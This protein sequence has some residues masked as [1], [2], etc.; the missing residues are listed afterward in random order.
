MLK[1][2]FSL[3]RNE[4]MGFFVCVVIIIILIVYRYQV[5]KHFTPVTVD[6]SVLE[7]SAAFHY[8]K[9]LPAKE[10][11]Y[12]YAQDKP[13][14]YVPKEVLPVELNSATKA[15]LIALRGVGEFYATKIIEMRKKMGG[16]TH[17]DQ[18]KEVYGMTDENFERIKPQLTLDA[19]LAKSKTKPTPV[20][21]K[22]S[23]PAKH[24][25][26]ELNTASKSELIALNGI[27]EFY[28]TKIIEKREQLGGFSH[29]DQLKM[30]YGMTAENFD[31]MRSQLR[32]DTTLVKEKIEI[33]TVDSLN[34]Y[35]IYGM[36]AE[37]IGRLLAYRERL[38]GFIS[39]EQLAEVYGLSDTQ[40]DIM[41]QR[42]TVNSEPIVKININTVTFK[43]L[44]RH[45]YVGGYDN[46][47]A[48]F[49]YRKYGDIKSWKEFTEIPNLKLENTALKVYLTY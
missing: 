49:A 24:V 47:K 29:I 26:V 20:T 39:V 11:S 10:T 3:T 34:L 30:V 6:L 44:L 13:E 2:Y 14:I 9:R 17:I 42:V 46:T 22:V 23:K 38:G 31:M 41:K 5:Q 25:I 37:L 36:N 19:T 33:N 4:R 16:F 21:K 28:A 15:Q 27:G 1:E 8:S 40:Y 35:D 45:P 32:L 48:I 12:T 18:L 43:A 7:D